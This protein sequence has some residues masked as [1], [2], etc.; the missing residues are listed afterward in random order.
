ML[1]QAIL[2]AEGISLTEADYEKALDDFAKLSGFEN[3]EE[4]ESM[5]SDATVLKG[6]VLWNVSL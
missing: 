4:I 5:Y 3:S 1:T 6:N 2:D